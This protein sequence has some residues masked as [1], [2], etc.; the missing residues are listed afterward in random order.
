MEESNSIKDV[1][2]TEENEEQI[3]PTSDLIEVNANFNKEGNGDVI[4]DLGLGEIL[5]SK[6]E[7]SITKVPTNLVMEDNADIFKDSGLGET[8]G[9][10][11]Q[12]SLKEVPNITEGKGEEGRGLTNESGLEVSKDAELYVHEDNVVIP[13]NVIN[14]DILEDVVPSVIEDSGVEISEII[15]KELIPDLPVDFQ[16]PM[17]LTESEIV[18]DDFLLDQELLKNELKGTDSRPCSKTSALQGI[19]SEEIRPPSTIE[20]E[21]EISSYTVNQIIH[22]FVEDILNSVQNIVDARETIV[23][24]EFSLSHTSAPSHL[25]IS[26]PSNSTLS[27]LEVSQVCCTQEQTRTMEL[28]LRS[29]IVTAPSLSLENLDPD[30]PLMRRFQAALNA[31]LQRQ[32]SRIAGELLEMVRF[33]TTYF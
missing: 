12:T 30:N 14:S 11:S 5:G 28:P 29:R 22:V 18:S 21:K 15:E 10:K 27:D 23:T 24:D 13:E 33:I 1:N 9:S 26:P 16:M 6:S 19:P 2:G 31:H 17:M 25:E 20:M 4:K 32:K 7:T 8:L 3:L